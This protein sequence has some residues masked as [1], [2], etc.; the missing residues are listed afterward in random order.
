MF[1]RNAFF[2]FF[3]FFFSVRFVC[4]NQFHQTNYRAN[5]VRLRLLA[6]TSKGT[7]RHRLCHTVPHVHSIKS[8]NLSKHRKQSTARDGAQHKIN[9]Q[10]RIGN[11]KFVLQNGIYF[12]FCCCLRA[13]RKGIR[14][15]YMWVLFIPVLVRTRQP[16]YVVRATAHD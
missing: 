10:K 2:F 14:L 5:N 15:V 1:S 8:V 4:A 12:F 7:I 16:N 9:M 13:P 3:F 11:E 6:N